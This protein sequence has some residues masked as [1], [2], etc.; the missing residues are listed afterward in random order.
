MRSS[1]TGHFVCP[2][3]RVDTKSKRIRSCQNRAGSHVVFRRGIK[4]SIVAKS[5]VRYANTKQETALRYCNQQT[6]DHLNSKGAGSDFFATALHQA[7]RHSTLPIQWLQQ[8]RSPLK[9]YVKSQHHHDPTS[10]TDQKMSKQESGDH[11]KYPKSNCFA[12][13]TLVFVADYTFCYP[14]CCEQ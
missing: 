7:F 6:L 13:Q 4:A 14:H 1:S 9:R 10:T 8:D 5:F 12:V 3:W 11:I 2:G